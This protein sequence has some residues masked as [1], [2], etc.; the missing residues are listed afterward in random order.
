[1]GQ[2]LAV[3]TG[4]ASGIGEAC[5]RTLAAAGARVVIADINEA[6]AKAVADSLGGVS[7]TL[8]VGDPDAIERVSEEILRAHGP[9]GILVNSAGIIQSPLPPESLPLSLWDDVVRIDQRGTYLCCCA[10]AR[11]MLAAEGGSIVNI[12]SITGMRAMPLHAYGPA[13]AAV[14]AMTRSLAVEW[15]RG[16]VRVNAVSPGY[17]L[18]P[19]LQAYIDQGLRDPARMAAYSALGRMVRA[20]EVAA[21]VSFLTTDA[22]SAITGANIPV[23]CG[24]I[25]G[26]AWAPYGGPTR[27]L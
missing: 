10:F 27:A 3:I 12:A 9:V 2:R 7:V 22:A 17:T 4:G 24:V 18:T 15:G 21:V 6:S 25:E 5:A 13:K 14:I 8:D 26:L 16:N 20:E 19:A 11:Q 23:D 1:M